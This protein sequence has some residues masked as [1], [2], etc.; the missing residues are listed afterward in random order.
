MIGQ[1]IEEL[2]VANIKLFFLCNMKADVNKDPGKFSKGDLVKMNKQD[3]GLCKKRAQLKSRID[4]ELSS[5]I[6]EGR[7]DVVEEIKK[8]GS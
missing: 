2:C 4:R 6:I 8:Y 1:L 3:I 7:M 5:S